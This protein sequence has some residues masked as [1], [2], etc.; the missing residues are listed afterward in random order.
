MNLFF[1]FLLSITIALI[2]NIFVHCLASSCFIDLKYDE[3]HNKSLIL[4]I[5][6][7]IIGLVLAKLFEPSQQNLT[8]SSG[9]INSPTSVNKQSYKNKIVSNGFLYGGFLLL[10]TAI[11]AS[12]NN[13]G[14]KIKVIFFGLLFF[15][16][17][18][19]SYNFSIH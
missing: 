3:K 5:L 16:V 4:I 8:V 11:L 6:F 19:C 2:Y 7:G 17:I 10:I 12:W 1:E 14:Q 9:A 15:A 18:W 13:I